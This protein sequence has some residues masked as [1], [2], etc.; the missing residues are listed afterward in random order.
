MSFVRPEAASALWRWRE[1]ITGVLI[2]GLGIWWAME[3]Q[4]RVFWIGWIVAAGGVAL[5]AAGLQRVRFRIPGQGPGIVTVTEG[6][7]TYF[8]P[9]TGGVVALSELNQIS[10]DPSGRPGHWMLSQPGQL[11][12]YIPITADGADA[13]FD[14][15]ASLP[16]MRTEHMLTQMKRPGGAPSVIWQRDDVKTK[17]FALH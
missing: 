9:L 5:I 1:V 8:G 4:G 10:F 15:F 14:A 12:L 13:L 17:R 3:T 6:Q 2:A 16:G 7:I 11:D